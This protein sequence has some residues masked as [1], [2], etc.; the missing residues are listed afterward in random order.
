MN[1]QSTIN[2][3]VVQTILRD[4]KMVGYKLYHVLLPRGKAINA[5][6]DWDLWGPLLLC[7]VMA[8]SFFQCVCVLGYCLFPLTISTIIIFILP[9]AVD[10]IYVRLPIAGGFYFWSV[11]ASYGFLAGSVPDTRKLLAVYPVILFYL[12]IAYLVV[13]QNK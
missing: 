6:R 10:K 9:G 7:L 11:F 8:L 12:V 3:P 1:G 4:L 13:S 2:E 5:L